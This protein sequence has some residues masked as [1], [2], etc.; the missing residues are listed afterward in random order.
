MSTGAAATTPVAAYTYSPTAPQAV[1]AVQFDASSS[2]D[3]AG[4]IRSYA[5]TFGD[6]ATATGATPTHTFGRAGSYT[7]TLRITDSA[8]KTASVSRAVSVSAPRGTPVAAF[9]FLPVAP[10]QRQ[11]VSFSGNASRDLTATI[12]A[13]SWTFGDGTTATGATPRHTYLRAGTYPVTLTVRDTTGQTAS[14]AHSVTVH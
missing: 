9:T 1:Q 4:T 5:W 7:V 10:A 3:G 8:G 14:V 12:S 6:G 13:Y 2:T 11:P